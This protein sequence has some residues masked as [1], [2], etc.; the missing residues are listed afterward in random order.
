MLRMRA[1]LLGMGLLAAGLFL[2]FSAGPAHAGGVLSPAC[3][4][5]PKN[6]AFYLQNCCPRPCPVFDQRLYEANLEKL[7]VLRQ[8]L[9]TAGLNEFSLQ[10]VLAG[11][12]QRIVSLP[13]VASPLSSY[14][15]LEQESI[16]VCIATPKE[17]VENNLLTPYTNPPETAEQFIRRA[18]STALWVQTE[19]A[20]LQLSSVRERVGRKFCRASLKQ[21]YALEQLAVAMSA[22][23]TLLAFKKRLFEHIRLAASSAASCVPTQGLATGG[24][25]ELQNYLIAA[26][27]QL[28]EAVGTGDALKLPDLP[29]CLRQDLFLNT[30]LRTEQVLL[31]TYVDQLRSLYNMGTVFSTLTG[32]TEFGTSY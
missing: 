3:I 8:W 22:Q 29:G 7:D 18:W 9:G 27:K 16:R 21:G 30:Q 10:L 12:G 2:W 25:N 1:F 6:T 28:T 23:S 5:A 13:L 26:Q 19:N 32:N 4:A 11:V 24:S 31:K 15:I 20:P 14:R 17:L